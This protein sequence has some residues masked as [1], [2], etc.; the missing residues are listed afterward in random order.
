MLRSCHHQPGHR[1]CESMVM[2]SAPIHTN[3]Y[4]H[5][6]HIMALTLRGHA[7]QHAHLWPNTLIE[8]HKRAQQAGMTC[9]AHQ[10]AGAVVQPSSMVPE[11][12]GVEPS[13]AGEQ[14]HLLPQSCEEA[15]GSILSQWQYKCEAPVCTAPQTPQEGSRLAAS[16]LK[17]DATQEAGHHMP[18]VQL[19]PACHGAHEMQDK[20]AVAVAN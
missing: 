13:G 9:A 14:V 4:T 1:V 20:E 7:L 2:V 12:S 3:T 18:C 17:P 8:L 16:L 15:L 5:T 19:A 10:L 6:R 11:G